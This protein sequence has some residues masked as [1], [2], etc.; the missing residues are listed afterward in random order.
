MHHA[1]VPR[2]GRAIGVYDE[3][4][5]FRLNVYHRPQKGFTIHRRCP[6]LLVAP[7]LGP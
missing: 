2:L 4:H 6:G 1:V 7:A 5:D 3:L